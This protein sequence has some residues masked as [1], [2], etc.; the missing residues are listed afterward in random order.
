MYVMV[1]Y[2]IVDDRTRYKVMKFL[3]DFGNRVQLSVFE[4]DISEE[5]FERM[6]EGIEELIDKNNDRVRYYKLCKSCI[7]NVKISGWGDI[8]ILDEGFRIV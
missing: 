3:K 5:Q 1:S 2:D 8:D 4:C 6:K 7:K